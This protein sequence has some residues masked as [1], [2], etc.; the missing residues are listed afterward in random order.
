MPALDP[1]LLLVLHRVLLL[2][3]L[4][5]LLVSL[6]KSSAQVVQTLLSVP[7]ACSIRLL[8]PCGFLFRCKPP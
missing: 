5:L 2:L 7:L 6:P 8:R 3:L 4:P 1:P